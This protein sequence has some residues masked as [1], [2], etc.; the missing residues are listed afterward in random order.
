MKEQL[1]IFDWKG[2]FAHF[3]QFD[4]NS[5]SLSYSI[6]PPTAISGMVA[7]LLGMERDTYYSELNR[8]NLQLAVQ[9]KSTPRK[10]MQT[11][12]YIFAKSP[13]DLNMAAKHTQIP[14]ELVVSESFPRAPLHYRIYL[15]FREASLAKR[16]FQTLEQKRMRYLPYMGSA[17]FASWIDWAAQPEDVDEMMTEQPVIIDSTADLESIEMRTLSLEPIDGKPPAIFR[18]HMRRE[19]LPGREPGRMVDILWEKN[20]HKIQAR[21]KVPVYRIKIGQDL[22]HVCFC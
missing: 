11:M 6:P 7:G 15:K 20:R 8:E 14:F 16:L 1:V 21:F 5:S 10:I 22:A 18:E 3:R 12:N 19:F 2:Y 4:S 17:P 9:L 13:S